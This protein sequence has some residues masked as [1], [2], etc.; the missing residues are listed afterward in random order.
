MTIST[1]HL[2][3]T[4]G[5]FAVAS[6]LLYI[7]IQFVHPAEDA[8]TVTTGTWS[9]VGS[10]TEFMATFGMVGVTGIYLRQVTTSGILG[11]IG[12]VLFWCFYLL[13]AAFN[14]AETLI[15]PP[16]AAQA[17]QFVNSFE[18]I[19]TETAPQ[20]DIGVLPAVSPIAAVLYMLGGALFGLAIF[21]ARVLD[22]WAG[23]LRAVGAVSTL[24]V[25][26]LPHA[27]GRFAAIPV[28]LAMVWLGY[29]L[30]TLERRTILPHGGGPLL[31][32]STAT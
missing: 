4:A 6:G 22:R 18:G 13:T 32:L 21:R 29:S 20:V 19:F 23:A 10:M 2:T 28:G 9:I 15:M 11:L 1:S 24:A 5:V 26:L 17:P 31:D 8:A 30:W 3:R 12:F 16:L 14:F 25:P 27:V 7:I